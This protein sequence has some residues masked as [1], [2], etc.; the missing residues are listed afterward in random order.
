[1][2]RLWAYQKDGAIPYVLGGWSWTVTC[3][4]DDFEI[5]QESE[6]EYSIHRKK[7]K[8]SSKSGF[9]CMG[10]IGRAAQVCDIPFY[11]KN[12]TTLLKDLKALEKSD[13]VSEGDMIWYPGHVMVVSSVKKGLVIEAV[14]YERGDGKV[15]EHSIE[16]VFQDVH[17][18][19]ELKNRVLEKKATTV[20]CYDGKKWGTYKNIKILKINSI[21]PKN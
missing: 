8:H 12:T 20:I 21:F 13:Q 11:I 17:S 1:M 5:L 2:L 15:E 16:K 14:G 4:N 10:I 6:T 9:D 19:E 7:W 3:N 18:F